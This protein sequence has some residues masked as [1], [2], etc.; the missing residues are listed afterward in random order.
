MLQSASV[1]QRLQQVFPIP[2][3]LLCH[4]QF[5]QPF[6][7][8]NGRVEHLSFQTLAIYPDAQQ[9]GL[10]VSQPLGAQ[11]VDD[12]QS[13]LR[14]LRSIRHHP[15]RHLLQLGIEGRQIVSAPC[16]RQRPNG[17]VRLHFACTQTLDRHRTILVRKLIDSEVNEQTSQT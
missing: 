9:V 14:L 12:V 5:H 3:I 11:R 1:H 17:M 13:P 10:I 2:L 8:D 4:G 6:A 16:V 7:D 15:L